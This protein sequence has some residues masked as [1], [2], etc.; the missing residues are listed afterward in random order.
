MTQGPP[1]VHTTLQAPAI[2]QTKPDEAVAI[3]SRDDGTT[4]G[5]RCRAAAMACLQFQC[6]AFL[7]QA[8]PVAGAQIL[9]ST[10]QRVAI[11]VEITA[12]DAGEVEG[13]QRGIHQSVGSCCPAQ[14]PLFDLL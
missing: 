6:A 11:A 9:S 12:A 7:S 1:S 10:A 5:D 3:A 8:Q 14:R 4:D 13:V 2:V